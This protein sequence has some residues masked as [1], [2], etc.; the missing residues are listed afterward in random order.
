[1]TA[2]Q[3]YYRFAKGL[4]KDARFT[5]MIFA[6]LLLSEQARTAIDRGAI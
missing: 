5:S 4:T 3:I 6:V 2:Q 1:V